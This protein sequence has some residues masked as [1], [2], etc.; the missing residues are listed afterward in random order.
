MQKLKRYFLTAQFYTVRIHKHWNEF[1]HHA[2][3]IPDII[4]IN[5]IL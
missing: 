5:V 4:F 3:I 1:I 2:L